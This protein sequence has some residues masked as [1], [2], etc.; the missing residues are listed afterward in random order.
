MNQPESGTARPI[1][2]YGDPVLHRACKSVEKFDEELETLIDDM[3]ASMHAAGGVGLAANQIGVD[4]RVFVMDCP[5]DDG[6][7]VVAHV[8]NPTLHEAAPP[9]ELQVSQEGCL[10]VPEQYTE[11]PRVFTA[12]VSGFDK[13]GEP[14]EITSTGFAARCLQ[15]ECDHLDGTVFVDRLP[16]KQRKKM[17]EAAGLKEK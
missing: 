11:T 12:T 6:N 17:L 1:V 4:A 8:V 13:T 5:D 3:F 14:V 15:H 2:L 9:R 10:S 7:R 16:R